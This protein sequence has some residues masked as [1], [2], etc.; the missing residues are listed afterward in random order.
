M[1]RF[2]TIYLNASCI[3]NIYATC[4]LS[5]HP[6]N[7]QCIKPTP[8]I[9]SHWMS[10]LSSFANTESQNT[11]NF[12]FW[13]I[14]HNQTLTFKRALE[15]WIILTLKTHG[16]LSLHVT[17]LFIAVLFLRCVCT[18]LGTAGPSHDSWQADADFSIRHALTPFPFISLKCMWQEI[19]ILWVDWLRHVGAPERHRV[20]KLVKKN[21]GEG[22]W[23]WIGST[24]KWSGGASRWRHRR[25]IGRGSWAKE[26]KAGKPPV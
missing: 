6:I 24:G 25:W 17:S 4:N 9:S 7:S 20:E 15:L 19:G 8:S 2:P 11:Q 18:T 26:R 16:Q 1:P 12:F 5:K 3:S 14:Q 22:G 21:T 10:C 13:F 23:G